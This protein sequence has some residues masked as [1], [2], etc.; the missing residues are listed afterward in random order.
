MRRRALLILATVVLG[1]L[2]ASGAALAKTVTGT[3]QVDDL[4]GTDKDDTIY[5]KGGNDYIF[6]EQANDVLR[7][8]LGNDMVFGR[9]GNDQI[10]GD[11]GSDE[12]FG[13]IGVDR[14]NAADGEKDVVNCG[15]DVDTAYVDKVDTF[16]KNCEN[17]FKRLS[18]GQTPGAKPG[19]A[20][21]GA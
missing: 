19:A 4:V 12:L 14:I 3:D 15:A 20:K 7:G 21:P 11:A 10:Y 18:E 2:V 13:D 1:V 6:G 16:N 8:G 17:V 5:G 9:D